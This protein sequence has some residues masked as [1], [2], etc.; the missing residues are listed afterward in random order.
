MAT[1]ESTLGTAVSMTRAGLCHCIK[2]SFQMTFD[3]CSVRTRATYTIAI[4][5]VL[6]KPQEAAWP[7][8]VPGGCV[9][10]FNA[11]CGCSLT[12]S[13]EHRCATPLCAH[14]S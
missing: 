5:N 8:I 7:G 2:S 9:P 12:L 6:L 4:A 11:P 13:E 14:S 1:V 3:S 10:L